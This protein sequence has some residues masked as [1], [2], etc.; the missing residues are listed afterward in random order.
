MQTVAFGE[1]KMTVLEQIEAEKRI[2]QETQLRKDHFILNTP[3]MTV[4]PRTSAGHFGNAEYTITIGSDADF[5]VEAITGTYFYFGHS[6]EDNEETLFPE[7]WVAPADRELVE[8]DGIL[9]FDSRLGYGLDDAAVRITDGRSQRL[10]TDNF[11]PLQNI[12]SGGAIDKPMMMMIPFKH[13]CKANGTLRLELANYTSKHL[14]V[15]VCFHGT[16]FFL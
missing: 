6:F 2:L 10:L 3:K 15:M 4:K 13:Y 12:L 8:R 9:G 16:K 5:L 14:R 7:R 11:C 1:Q